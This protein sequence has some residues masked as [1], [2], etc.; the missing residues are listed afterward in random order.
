MDIGGG[1][2][3]ELDINIILLKDFIPGC[4]SFFFFF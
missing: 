2:A 4:S 1:L 3:L